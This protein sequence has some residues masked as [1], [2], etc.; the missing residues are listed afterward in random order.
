MSCTLIMPPLYAMLYIYLLLQLPTK[1]PL[2]LLIT[3]KYMYSYE[4][5]VHCNAVRTN[6]KHC[7]TRLHT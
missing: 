6:A 2:K 1:A 5:Y 4:V 3:R 7:I